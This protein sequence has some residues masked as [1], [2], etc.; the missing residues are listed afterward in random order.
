MLIKFA[1]Q[2]FAEVLHTIHIYIYIY[3]VRGYLVSDLLSDFELLF[4]L[5]TCYIG[6]VCKPG[7]TA[8]TRYLCVRV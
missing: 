6:V 3:T 4:C 1:D 8:S 2:H 7:P 5:L